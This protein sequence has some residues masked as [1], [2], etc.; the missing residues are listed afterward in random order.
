MSPDVRLEPATSGQN[1][2][3]ATGLYREYAAS[4]PRDLTLQEFDDEIRSLPGQYAPPAGTIVVA[5]G[6]GDTAIGC[7]ALRPMRQADACEM[8]RLYVAPDCRGRGL[9]FMLVGAAIEAAKT[10]GYRQIYLDTLASMV[11]AQALYRRCGFEPVEPYH[12]A[13]VEGM[14]FFRL[15]LD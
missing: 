11:E 4:L 5:R 8:K 10:A 1:L 3:D 14:L 9:G 2:P 12:S 7:V 15:S 6:P 13:T